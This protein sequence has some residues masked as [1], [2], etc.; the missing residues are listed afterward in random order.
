MSEEEEETSADE[1]IIA[2]E[3]K[4]IHPHTQ[5]LR[6]KFVEARINQAQLMDEL[7]KQLL[8]LELAIPG[9]Y[10][11]VW[12]LVQG[13]AG[14]VDPTRWFYLTFA[15]WGGA[16]FCTIWALVPKPYRVDENL[17]ARDPAGRSETMSLTEF[18]D[19]SAEYKR[20]WLI[21]SIFLFFFG[22]VFSFFITAIPIATP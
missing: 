21:V 2:V 15:L 12:K 19:R 5:L 17:I 9:L 1:Q 8:T 13:D 16:L 6:E 4:P 3:S 10:A 11:T 22:I 7:A 20:G 18:F 14:Q